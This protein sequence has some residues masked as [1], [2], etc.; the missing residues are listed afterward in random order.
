MFF[1][2]T[3][4]KVDLK[5]LLDSYTSNYYS[6]TSR[7]ISIN[8]RTDSYDPAD[9]CAQLVYAEYPIILPEFKDTIWEETLNL[10]PGKKSRARIHTI[11][12]F[13]LLES[14]RDFEKRYHVALITDPACKFVDMENDMLYHIPADGYVYEIDTRMMHTFINASN[15]CYRTHLVVCQYD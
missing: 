13:S 1:K 3:D 15:N 7:R 5:S 11:A 8:S 14:H 10:L 4:I 2:K 9:L 6:E 12:P